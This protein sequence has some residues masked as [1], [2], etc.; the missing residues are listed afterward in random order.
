M[1]GFNQV[2]EKDKDKFRHD[3]NIYKKIIQPRSLV[4]SYENRYLQ[5]PSKL[6]MHWMG[7]FQ[8]ININE[9]GSSKIKTHLARSHQW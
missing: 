3:R 2:V 6:C 9:I 8:P 1:K 7:P 4:L 5:Y